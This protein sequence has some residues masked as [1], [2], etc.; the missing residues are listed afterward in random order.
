MEKQ[1]DRGVA[2]AL[3]EL[4]SSP[5][6][7][8]LLAALLAVLATL[9]L[10]IYVNAQISSATG[11]DMIEVL[12][13]A[14]DLPP[15]TEITKQQILTREIPAAYVHPKTVLAEQQAFVL[16]QKALEDMEQGE[17]LLWS[18]LVMSSRSELTDK[19]GFGERAMTIAVDK[20]SSQAGQI[21]PGD[22][23]DVLSSLDIPGEDLGSD[24]SEIRLLLQNITILAIDGSIA[25]SPTAGDAGGGSDSPVANLTRGASG[26]VSAGGPTSATLKLTAE[27]ARHLAY[28]EEHG[29]V[30]LLLRNPNDVI[31]EAPAAVTLSDLRS[32]IPPSS[33]TKGPDFSSLSKGYPTVFEKGV[34]KGKAYLPRS[35]GKGLREILDSLDDAKVDLTT[36]STAKSTESSVETPET[37]EASAPEQSNETEKAPA[38]PAPTPSP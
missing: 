4:Q 18:N 10:R 27:Q 37:A 28:A 29:R 7:V 26:A 12:L 36:T 2:L 6:G 22:R 11:G 32:H 8:L 38:E 15:G 19:L 1:P 16:G 25:S 34:P 17:A 9:A 5:L 3:R 33:R 35:A 23:V 21:R 14:E 31:A 13:A 24:S 20:F 30:M